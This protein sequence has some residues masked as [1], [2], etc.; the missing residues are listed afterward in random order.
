MQY[1]QE[2]LASNSNGRVPRVGDGGFLISPAGEEGQL[3]EEWVDHAGHQ[4]IA[5][6][7]VMRDLAFMTMYPYLRKRMGSTRPS[8]AKA[9]LTT[10]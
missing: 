8:E 10:S 5:Q 2:K 1:H 3:E 9:F 4:L 6:L 7:V